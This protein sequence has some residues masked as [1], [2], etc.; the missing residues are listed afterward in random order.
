[1]DLNQS[2]KDSDK[3]TR[4]APTISLAQIRSD[5]VILILIKKAV[6]T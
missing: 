4:A 2:L 5:V 3:I 6:S 1:M